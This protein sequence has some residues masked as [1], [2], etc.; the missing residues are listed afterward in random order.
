MG[1]KEKGKIRVNTLLTFDALFTETSGNKIREFSPP[2]KETIYSLRKTGCTIL[3]KEGKR[4][5]F[6]FKMQKYFVIIY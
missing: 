2:P 6:A 4:D 3:K 5:F 1:S